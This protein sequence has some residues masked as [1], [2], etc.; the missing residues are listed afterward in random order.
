MSAPPPPPPPPRMSIAHSQ[1]P[2]ARQQQRHE[3][4]GPRLGLVAAQGRD[5]VHEQLGHGLE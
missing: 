4:H 1:Q 3:D 2:C 5:E